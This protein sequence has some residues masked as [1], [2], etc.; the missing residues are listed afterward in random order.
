MSEMWGEQWEEMQKDPDYY[1]DYYL[2]HPDEFD[3]REF[4]YSYPVKVIGFFDS[5]LL[6]VWDFPAEEN[7][8]MFE[9]IFFCDYQTAI[10]L[11]QANR[12]NWNDGEGLPGIFV[13]DNQEM[14][15]R[16]SD[17]SKLD[18]TMMELKK[19]ISDADLLLWSTNQDALAAS[20]APLQWMSKVIILF[21]VIVLVASL[22]LLCLVFLFWSKTRA[23]EIWSLVSLGEKRSSILIQL[24]IECLI[25]SI[26]AIA[27]SVPIVVDIE[28]RIDASQFVEHAMVETDQ[29]MLLSRDTPWKTQNTHVGVRRFFTNYK[30]LTPTSIKCEIN[31]ISVLIT[32]LLNLCTMVFAIIVVNRKFLIK[33]LL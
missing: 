6:P 1:A 17:P 15:F 12:E 23:R 2:N 3:S 24:I 33:K 20:V 9:N 8:Y 26:I 18:K 29:K 5:D 13:F 4:A 7:S 27:F 30:N 16:L 32:F 10:L 11:D 19:L 31:T 22:S 14:V 28:N 25:L 21:I